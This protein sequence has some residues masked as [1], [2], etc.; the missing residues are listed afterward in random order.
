VEISLFIKKV[1]AKKIVDEVELLL[2][3]HSIKFA[4]HLVVLVQLY[5]QKAGFIHGFCFVS[6][7]VR[8]SV[9]LKSLDIVLFIFEKLL[10]S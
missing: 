5:L 3:T 1:D 6:M 9:L 4:G 7:Q 10:L 8:S 2:I